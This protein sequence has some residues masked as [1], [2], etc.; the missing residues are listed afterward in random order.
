MLLQKI[1]SLLRR[2]FLFD[3]YLLRKICRETGLRLDYH[4]NR[5][6]LPVL[7]DIFINREYADYFPAQT[8]AIVVDVGAHYGYFAL[9]AALNLSE[10]SI[11]H[12][13]EPSQENFNKLKENIEVNS[14]FPI[15]IH[16][17]GLDAQAGERLLY[18]GTSFN[19][20]FYGQS[21]QVAQRVST[22]SL[23]DF[24]EREKL[25]RVDLLKLD[26]EG[27]EFPILLHTDAETLGRIQTIVLEFHDLP[28]KGYTSYQLVDHLRRHGFEIVRYQHD[29][30]YSGRNLNFGKIIATRW[31]AALGPTG[32]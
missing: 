23:R 16:H 29:P 12:S 22:L 19:H 2:L 31:P 9:F 25:A 24:I 10:K 14:Q 20:S 27:A 4:R 15:Q 30:D 11:I 6:G 8:P 28:E 17:T 26:C 5:D 1:D 7:E 13:I 32:H 3:R 18:G 21:H